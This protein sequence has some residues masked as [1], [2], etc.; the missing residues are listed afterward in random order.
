MKIR[1][2]LLLALSTL[3]IVLIVLIGA[4]WT[5]ISHLNNASKVIKDNYDASI[6][7]G[8]IR[9]DIKDEGIL[10]RNLVIFTDEVAVQEE[11]A[12]LRLESESI[13]KNISLL[14]TKTS[15]KVQEEATARLI[16]LNND[17][18]VYKEK[19]ITF[20]SRK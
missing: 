10:L 19:V 5:Q 16:K 15:S 11:I 14:E 20:F 18:N 7:A 2:K 8:Q 9:A 17:F 3:P 1:T 4:G 12:Q 13:K 6:L